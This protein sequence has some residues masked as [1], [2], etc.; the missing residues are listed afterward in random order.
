MPVFKHILVPT[1]GSEGSLRAAATAV[2]LA[3]STGAR[4]TGFFAAPPATPIVFGA[5]LPAAY[6]PPEEHAAVIARM[7]QAHLGAIRKLAEAADVR[8]AG[9]YETSDFPAEAILDIAAKYHCDLICIAPHSRHGLAT[10]L[11]SQTQKVVA[12][13]TVPVLVVR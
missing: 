6:L 3:K 13:A 12:N 1:D 7:T 5:F 11:G 8:F 10:L 4:I 2:A 9:V